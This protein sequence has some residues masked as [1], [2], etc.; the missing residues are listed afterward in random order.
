M[1]NPSIGLVYLH[2][3]SLR[4]FDSALMIIGEP[5]SVSE[6]PVVEPVLIEVIRYKESEYDYVETKLKPEYN[7]KKH[8]ISSQHIPSKRHLLRQKRF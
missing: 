4:Q 7:T 6:F 2:I 1:I 5:H 3:I 8:L